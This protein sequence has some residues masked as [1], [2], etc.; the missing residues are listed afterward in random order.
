MNLNIITIFL[1]CYGIPYIR[2]KCCQEEPNKDPKL[3]ITA[4]NGSNVSNGIVLNISQPRFSIII[5]CYNNAGYV[6][7]CL[8][9]IKKQTF[10][11]TKVQVIAINDASTDGSDEILELMGNELP[12]FTLINN[13]RNAGV[14]AARNAAMTHATGKYVYF[15]DCDDYLTE[16]ALERIND[17]LVK[18]N[19]PDVAFVPFLTLDNTKKPV[20]KPTGADLLTAIAICPPGPWA[21]VFKRTL[22]IPFPVGFRAEDTV[23]H[24]V[25]VD[26]FNNF[27]NVTGDEPCYIYDR[28]NTSAITDTLMWSAQNAF[29]L[30]HLAKENDAIKAGKNDK[31][32]S[33]VLRALAEMYD[34]R[35]KIMK[36]FIK[37]LWFAR[38]CSI[39][40]SMVCGHFHN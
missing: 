23:W 7:R 21:K 39:Y 1:D 30:E 40:Q 36:P 26:R 10:D 32:F 13:E 14:G 18:A 9:A 31:F 16:N 2:Y 35:H 8:K 15:I 3:V 17:A 6:V 11:I 5:P 34:S 20:H 4:A 33:D 24:F 27:C 29:T 19:D 38:F 28:T 25:Q 12:D 22:F 37:N